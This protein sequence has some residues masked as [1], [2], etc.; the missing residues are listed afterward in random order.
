[1][2]LGELTEA[3]FIDLDHGRLHSK[4]SSYGIRDG[5]LA[6]FEEFFQQIVFYLF[7]RK[8]FVEFESAISEK[9][10]V[11]AGVPQGSV[12]G[13]LLFVL[14]NYLLTISTYNC[15]NVKSFCT[16]AT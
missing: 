9:Q 6:W 5:E 4:L 16:Q 15:R 11:I 3:V 1:M 12:L 7:G 14:I 2:D 13:P 8:Q 10:T